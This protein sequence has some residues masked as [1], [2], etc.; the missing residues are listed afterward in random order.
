MKRLIVLLLA[1]LVSCGILVGCTNNGQ[2]A[3]EV[4]GKEVLYSEYEIYLNNEKMKIENATGRDYEDV[5]DIQLGEEKLTYESVAKA[6]VQSGIVFNKVCELMFEQ[7]GLSYTEEMEAET[8]RLFQ[9]QAELAGGVKSYQEKLNSVGLDEEKQKQYLKALVINTAVKNKMYGPEG[10][11]P[12]TD[13]EIIDEL[14]YNYYL[15]QPLVI[16]KSEGNLMLTG[17]ALQKKQ[18]KYKDARSAI[19][20]GESFKDVLAQYGEAEISD[21]VCER[22]ILIGSR[23][24]GNDEYKAVLQSAENIIPGQV[25]YG[26]TSLG[27]YALNCLPIGQ[28]P[29]AWIREQVRDELAELKFQQYMEKKLTEVPYTLSVS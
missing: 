22:G 26:E 25:I 20:S 7:M 4:G 13:Q 17:A 11:T 15:V 3:L 19:D 6:N 5:K 12:I 9:Q 23:V 1:G 21:E 27:F 10:E 14:Q 28:E 29:E 18:K 8:E 24:A 16:Y 2:I